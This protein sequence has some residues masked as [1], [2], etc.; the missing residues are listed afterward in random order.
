MLDLEQQMLQVG[1][2]LGPSREPTLPDWRNHAFKVNKPTLG[3]SPLW[4]VSPALEG[5]QHRPHT[6]PRQVPWPGDAQ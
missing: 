4:L 1:S 5:L 2:V 6:A 3:V